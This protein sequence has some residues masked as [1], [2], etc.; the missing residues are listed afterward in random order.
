MQLLT[1]FFQVKQWRH[2]NLF[3]NQ[4][5][6]VFP[7]RCKNKHGDTCLLLQAKPVTSLPVVYSLHDNPVLV[8]SF[9]PP[10]YSHSWQTRELTFNFTEIFILIENNITVL[11]WPSLSPDL[12]LIE[13]L[14]MYLK[15]V[16]ARRPLRHKDKSS[17]MKNAF[18]FN[19]L[20]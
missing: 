10:N 20:P 6:L 1:K 19:F 2:W 16:M 5:L 17:K 7:V 4:E 13:N 9:K 14:L 12:N 15:F 11:L 3:N 8:E 18:R